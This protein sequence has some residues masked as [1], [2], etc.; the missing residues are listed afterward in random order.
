[1]AWRL[2]I[3]LLEFYV[4]SSRWL[5]NYL[6][7]HSKSMRNAKQVLIQF[8]QS[9][10]CRSLFDNVF[11]F[12]LFWMRAI[13]MSGNWWPWIKRTIICHVFYFW[14]W[15][16]IILSNRLKGIRLCIRHFFAHNLV[17]QIRLKITVC[18]HQSLINDFDIEIGH[19]FGFVLLFHTIQHIHPSPHVC[20][21]LVYFGKHQH[22]VEEFDVKQIQNR[23]EM[24]SQH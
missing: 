21:V 22:S 18:A 9:S 15:L 24:W 19:L 20:F 7:S 2:A 5:L 12:S 8:Q 11:C 23:D 4:N 13:N 14:Q 10:K 1:M 6:L 16:L 3:H 17:A